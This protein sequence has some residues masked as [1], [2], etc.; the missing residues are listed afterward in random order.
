LVVVTAADDEVGVAAVLRV[1]RNCWRECISMNQVWVKIA[2]IE[3][4]W[5]RCP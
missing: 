5:W 4:Y 2:P 3:A 1:K